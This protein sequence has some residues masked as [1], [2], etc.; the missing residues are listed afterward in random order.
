LPYLEVKGVSL[1]YNSQIILKDIDI[2]V[3]LGEMLGII[4]PN[5]SGKS[6]LIRAISGVLSP[7]SGGISIE[8]KD[9]SKLS[10]QKLAHLVA[11]VPQ[12]P[13]LP[14]SF[15]ALELV[16]LGRYPHL[17]LLRY[18]SQKDLSIAL[19]AMEKT[20]VASFAKRR[21]SQL[22]GG[23]RQRV[24]IARALA[25]Q[26]QVIL[27]DEPTA[28]LD[29]Q[30]QLQIMELISDLAKQ[31]KTTI[32]AIH[33]FSLA[34]RYCHRLVM[35]GDGQLQ[36][37]GSV[38]SVM[39]P[40]NIEAAFGLKALVYH[41]P[42]GDKLVISPFQR[43]VRRKPHRIHIIG[44]GGCGSRVIQ[45]L[46]QEGFELTAGVLNQGDADLPVATALCSEVVI[47]PP[48]ATIDAENYRQNQ[49]L[50][51]QADCVVLC[52]VPFGKANL[53]NLEAA[54]RAKRLILIEDNPI[55]ERDFTGG[56][57]LKIYSKLK[58]RAKC[59]PFKK[60]TRAIEEI[61]STE[62]RVTKYAG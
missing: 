11:V 18:E 31:G 5:G 55:K 27:F 21:I 42:I 23:E 59:T 54:N 48:F 47:I 61:L 39:T 52:D 58:T 57:A 29:L 16:L 4:G 33:D 41:D 44:G 40:E 36:A 37:E 13:T 50:I 49:E 45:M 7:H 56:A 53:P 8:G 51:A 17:G 62:R 32:T 3:N 6:T 22:S 28:H 14:E 30:H 35:L 38:L 12:N 10:H 20:A 34:A 24:L 46:H 60:L 9:I 26:S 1:G 15:T 2:G 43:K 19:E 25:Q